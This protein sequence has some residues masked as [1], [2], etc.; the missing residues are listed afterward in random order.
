LRCL[1]PFGRNIV[2]TG[3][4]PVQLTERSAAAIREWMRGHPGGSDTLV[5]RV[6][7]AG[8]RTDLRLVAAVDPATDLVGE[9]FGIRIAVPRSECAVLAGYVIDYRTVG[10]EPGF[11]LK[12]PRSMH[13]RASDPGGVVLS[14]SKLQ[15]LQPELFARTGGFFRRLLGSG[16]DS[17][18][19]EYCDSL[20]EHL[21]QG[22]SR[23][24]VVVSLAP[25]VVAAYT[26]E[27]D[28]VALLRFPED[29]VAEYGLQVGSRLLTV[30]RYFQGGERPGDLVPG[31]RDTRQYTNYIPIIADFL[32]TDRAR[33]ERRKAAIGEDEWE[34]AAE[35]GRALLG[36]GVTPRD[37]RP[38]HCDRPA[39]AGS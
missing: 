24:A 32:A 34:R 11:V 9:S 2:A 36:R 23:A 5:L 7:G 10:G 28:C 26:D 12:D 18:L 14:P 38:L 31:P 3:E 4:F 29:L 33:V 21:Q 15:R 37:G 25:L 8:G 16:R 20:S 35:M 6:S 17:G 27:L 19:E 22:D 30:N 1:G 39:T 13:S